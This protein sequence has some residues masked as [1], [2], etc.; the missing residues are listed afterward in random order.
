MSR[1]R[2]K[3]FINEKQAIELFT[4]AFG[5]KVVT[6]NWYQLRII[7]EEFGGSF[8]WYHTQ[9]SVVVNQNG[10]C[11]RFGTYSDAERLAVAI[12]NFVSNKNDVTE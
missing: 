12:N 8:D 6:M 5:F 3:C 9:G 7:H 4:Q 1:K 10:S 11:R 2:R